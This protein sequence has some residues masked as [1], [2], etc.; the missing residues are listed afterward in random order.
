MAED[1]PQCA[2]DRNGNLAEAGSEPRYILELHEEPPVRRLLLVFQQ[3]F[4]AGKWF[5]GGDCFLRA[6][7]GRFLVPL[8]D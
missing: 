2:C 6:L 8:R 1:L 5:I 3:G 7:R 4:Q